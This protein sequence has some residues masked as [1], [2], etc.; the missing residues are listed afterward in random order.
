M[1]KYIP[2]GKQKIGISE[3]WAVL[4]TLKSE[5][6]TQGPL[7]RRFEKEIE[8][9]V[10]CRYAVAVNSATSALHISCLSLG[11]REKEWVWTVPISFVASA[12][13]AK[14]CNAKVDFVDI[15]INTDLNN[16]INIYTNI[17]YNI[18]YNIFNDNIIFDTHTK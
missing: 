9:K 4:K 11:L 5:W 10:E 14:Y 15:D 16:K 1:R 2:Y 7:V 8:K 13:C 12:N 18:I 3:I 17:N 6:L